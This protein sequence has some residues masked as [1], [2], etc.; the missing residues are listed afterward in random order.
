MA[1]RKSNQVPK[2]SEGSVEEGEN[3]TNSRLIHLLQKLKKTWG[4]DFVT[5]LRREENHL[6]ILYEA[7]REIQVICFT[8][9]DKGISQH[10]LCYFKQ[11]PNELHCTSSS[12]KHEETLDSNLLLNDV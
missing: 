10:Q 1:E 8:T 2:T 3:K 6:Y 12:R 5:I 9:T 11:E 4:A 7:L